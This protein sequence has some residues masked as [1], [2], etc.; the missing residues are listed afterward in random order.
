M[1]QVKEPAANAP[2][3]V[4]SEG[5]ARA[6]DC[7]RTVAHPVR[8]QLIQLL[9][10]GEYTVG[11]LAAACGIPSHVASEHLGLMRDRQLLTY[12]RRGR[13]T[14]YRVA[15]RALEGIMNCVKRN[16]GSRPG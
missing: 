16:F 2:A 4:D 6:A 13:R 12:E 5:L 10:H 14:Y 1:M 11:E 7:L 15:N 8:L 3:L 9:L